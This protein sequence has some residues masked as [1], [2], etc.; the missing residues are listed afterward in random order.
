[1]DNDDISQTWIKVS[2]KTGGG[3]DAGMVVFTATDSA[4][5]SDMLKEY[6]AVGLASLVSEAT[7]HTQALFTVNK[8]LGGMPVEGAQTAQA[9]ERQ[10]NQNQNQNQAGSG[11][12]SAGPM[13]RPPVPPGEFAPD[14]PHGGQKVLID[15]R[16]GLFWGCTAPRGTAGACKP[17]KYIAGKYRA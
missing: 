5:M 7:T 3:Y 17:E 8:Q 16:Y 4:T 10:A 11:S 2:L 12:G 13:D 9:N 15:G 6:M 1:M 14:D